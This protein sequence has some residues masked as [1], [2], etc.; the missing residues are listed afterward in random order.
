[1]RN[2]RRALL[3]TAIAAASIGVA[4]PPAAACTDDNERCRTIN[5][6]CQTVLGGPCLR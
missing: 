2:V 5:F 4:A 3:A 6:V 1:M